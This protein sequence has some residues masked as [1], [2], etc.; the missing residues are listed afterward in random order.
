MPEL[1]STLSAEHQA[2]L[3]RFEDWC[4]ARLT[5]ANT[6]IANYVGNIRRALPSLGGN[7]DGGR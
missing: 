7:P 5:L 3:Q 6:S 4:Y 1:N 2:I